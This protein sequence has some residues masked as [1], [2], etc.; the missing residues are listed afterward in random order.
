MNIRITIEYDGEPFVGWQIQT[1]GPSIQETLE[2]AIQRVTGEYVF[3]R[4]AGRTDA[5]VHARAQVAN[6]RAPSAMTPDQWRKALN[7]LLPTTIRIL[8]AEEADPSFDALKNARGKVYEYRV[9]NTRVASALDRRVYFYPGRLDWESMA[10]CLPLFVGRQDF[11]CFQGARAS[12]KTTVRDLNR[13][14]LFEEPGGLFRFEIEGSGFLKQMVRAVVG[15]VI[16]VGEGRRD[17]SRIPDVIAS[18]DRRLAGRTLPACG[19][20]LLEVKY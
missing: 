6:F 11:R 2:K 18:G 3:V 14:E 16:E 15:T 20:C 4:G 17:G 1:N 12:V 9:L 10:R 7:A 19:L 13:F 5:G 8:Q